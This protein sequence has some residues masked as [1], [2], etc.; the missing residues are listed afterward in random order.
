MVGVDGCG[1]W[2][3]MFGVIVIGMNVVLFVVESF[4]FWYWCC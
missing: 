4:L 2:I 1:G 3:L